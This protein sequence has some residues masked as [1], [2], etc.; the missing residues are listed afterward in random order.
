MRALEVIGRAREVAQERGTRA[1][2]REARVRVLYV[3]SATW[4]ERDLAQPI[5]APPGPLGARVVL[6]LPARTLQRVPREDLHPE[7]LRTAAAYDHLLAHATVDGT[8]AGYVLA[9]VGQVYV[10]DYRRC[11][12]L[13]ADTAFIYDSFVSRELRGRRLLGQMVAASMRRLHERGIE[14]IFCHI[15]D[16]NVA[17]RRAYLRLGFKPVG[18]V[19]FAQIGG[20]NGPGFFVGDPHRLLRRR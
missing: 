15:P 19:T 8:V 13:P 6:D 11:L 1:L 17:S 4:Y 20:V 12:T 10:A 16:W 3:T 7:L 5:D 9:G 2:L 18:R 14:R